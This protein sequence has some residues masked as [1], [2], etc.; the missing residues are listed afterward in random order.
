ME[1]VPHSCWNDGMMSWN[2]Q[3]LVFQMILELI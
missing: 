3:S 1:F 2:D